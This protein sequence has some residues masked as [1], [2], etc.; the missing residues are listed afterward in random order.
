MNA[1]DAESAGMKEHQRVTVK[2]DAGKLEEVE[3]IYGKV[4]RGAAMMFYPEVNAIFT[5][6]VDPLSGTPAYKRV[7][8]VVY[9]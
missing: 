6:Q 5:A 7:P 1:E 2:G 4:R 9:S 3:I 8:I